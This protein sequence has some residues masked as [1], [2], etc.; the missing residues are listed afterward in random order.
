MRPGEAVKIAAYVQE[1]KRIP[2]RG[3]IGLS[4]DQI[5]DYEK[6]GYV[7]S[8]SR[9]VGCPLHAATAAA[10]AHAARAVLTRP[11]RAALGTG[12]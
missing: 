2:R 12:A 7:M 8:G 4:S 3:E 11:A 6:S 10:R 9:Y 1:G 5:E